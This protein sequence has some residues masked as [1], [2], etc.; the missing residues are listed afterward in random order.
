VLA[1][2]I[3][4]VPIT[5]AS[6]DDDFIEV[7]VELRDVGESVRLA[8]DDGSR[9][10]ATSFSLASSFHRVVP[11]LS[12]IITDLRRMPHAPDEVSMEVGLTVGGETGLIFTKGSAEA[13]F[14][15]NLTWKKPPA[16]R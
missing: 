15:V 12:S 9:A 6:G 5:D 13:T 11:A 14:T 7:E 1:Q 2:T 16:P 10:T 8:S 3:L 4:R